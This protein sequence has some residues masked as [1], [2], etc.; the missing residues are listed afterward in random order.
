MLKS[1]GSGPHIIKELKQNSGKDQQKKKG[2]TSGKEKPQANSTFKG[3]VLADFIVERPEEEGQDD[4][5]RKKTLFP[6]HWTLFTERASCVDGSGAWSDTSHRIGSKF[7]E[8]KQKADAFKQNSNYQLPHLANM[9]SKE[10]KE[11]S[12]NEIEVLAVVEEEGDSWMTPIH[13]YLTDET[14]PAERKKAREIKTKESIPTFA[15]IKEC[16][17][18]L[19]KTSPDKRTGRKSKPEFGGGNKSKAGQRQQEL[20][21]KKSLMSSGHTEPWS[22]L[23]TSKH[24]V[25]LDLRKR[26]LS[27]IA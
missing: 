13:E 10:L 17:F 19:R 27:H 22:N 12:V 26:S 20:D 18:C 5:T 7:Q 9:F 23:V 1:R 15:I 25:S 16:S 2:E 11:K 21:G 6:V 24:S 8:Q 14:L 4:S 3:Q